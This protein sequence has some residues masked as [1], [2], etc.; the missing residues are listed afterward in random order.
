[1]SWE[2]VCGLKLPGTSVL[3]KKYMSDMHRV[4]F[5]GSA[6]TQSTAPAVSTSTSCFHSSCEKVM[7]ALFLA[8]VHAV[9]P[10]DLAHCVQCEQCFR[11]IH[12]AC[13]KTSDNTKTLTCSV[14]LES[15][16]RTI[17]TEFDSTLSPAVRFVYLC[18]IHCYCMSLLR[19][20][21]P[22]SLAMPFPLCLYSKKSSLQTLAEV[23]T[24]LQQKNAGTRLKRKVLKDLIDPVSDNEHQDKKLPAGTG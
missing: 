15:V 13:I 7:F 12:T 20:E 17:S 18:S 11:G 10:Y 9:N 8:F 24:Q 5:S 14:C 22:T 6:S 1:M 23:K 21:L 2:G 19:V 16:R 4:M 3:A